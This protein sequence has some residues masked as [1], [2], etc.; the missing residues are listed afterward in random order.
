MMNI[1]EKLLALYPELQNFDFA[2]GVITLENASDDK[3]DYI[4]EWSHPT[5]SKPTEAQLKGF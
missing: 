2:A 4:A 1:R 5:L 3:G